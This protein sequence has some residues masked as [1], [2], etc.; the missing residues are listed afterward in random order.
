MVIGTDGRLQW[1]CGT[2]ART[3]YSVGAW[4][5]RVR[6]GERRERGALRR[7]RVSPVTLAVIKDSLRRRP[8]SPRTLGC[9]QGREA[10]SVTSFRPAY[11]PAVREDAPAWVSLVTRAVCKLTYCGMQMNPRRGTGGSANQGVELRAPAAT[12]LRLARIH[13]EPRSRAKHPCG[14]NGPV[15]RSVPEPR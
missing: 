2:E 7:A 13:L 3:A 12:L 4:G 6:V 1:N 8:L 5:Q 10:S 15:I 14:C 11:C 9:T